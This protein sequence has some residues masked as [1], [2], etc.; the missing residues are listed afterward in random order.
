M[1]GRDL[2]LADTGNKDIGQK[3]RTNHDLL[4]ELYKLNRFILN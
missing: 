2:S 4:H 3:P 1:I